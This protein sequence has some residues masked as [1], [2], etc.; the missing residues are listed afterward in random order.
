M[1]LSRR[2]VDI[3]VNR[4]YIL[5]AMVPIKTMLVFVAVT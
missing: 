2:I 4:R 1:F 5:Y 3:G